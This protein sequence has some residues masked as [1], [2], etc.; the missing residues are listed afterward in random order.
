M[1]MASPSWSLRRPVPASPPSDQSLGGYDIQLHCPHPHHRLHG[2]PQLSG[3]PS[4]LALGVFLIHF[5]L[6]F[7]YLQVG[8]VMMPPE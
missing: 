3:V 1:L 7:S 4:G 6:Q 5:P 8:V 2:Q